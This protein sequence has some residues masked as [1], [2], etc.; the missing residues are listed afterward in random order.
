VSTI[1]HIA[2]AS[3]WAQARA[4]GK[5]TT[6]TRGKTLAEQGFI[7]GST[8]GQ[9]AP[10]AN[11]IYKGL[12]DLLVLVIDTDR[13]RPEVRYEPV[14]GWDEPFP[15]IYGPLN[16]DA[17]IETRPLDPGPDGEFSFAAQPDG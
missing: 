4:D 1:Y 7:H 2:T 10:V 5:Y 9:V 17:V 3:D 15:H 16:T 13:V 12:P 6:S 14:T 11:M 8:A